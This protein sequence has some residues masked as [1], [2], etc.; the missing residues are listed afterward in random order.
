MNNS[1]NEFLM[2]YFYDKKY[3]VW[4]EFLVFLRKNIIIIVEQIFTKMVYL[5]TLYKYFEKVF[6]SK[7][8]TQM[9]TLG[10]K[11]SDLLEFVYILFKSE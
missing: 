5:N 11:L 1:C 8:N 4:A 2:H 3:I 10:I 9:I 6:I 7:T